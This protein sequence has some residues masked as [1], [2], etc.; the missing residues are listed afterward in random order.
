MDK[1]SGRPI[2]IEKDNGFI[3]GFNGVSPRGEGAP[4]GVSKP[5]IIEGAC[6]IG[7]SG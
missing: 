2:I 6:D 7:G 1:T 5:I 3:D 4:F